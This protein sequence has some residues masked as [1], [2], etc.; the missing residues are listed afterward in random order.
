MEI[1]IEYPTLIKIGEKNIVHF[2]W[3]PKYI[4]VLQARLKRSLL[5]KFYRAVWIADE[6]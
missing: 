6:V 2:T 1:C 3:R 4:S 5:V